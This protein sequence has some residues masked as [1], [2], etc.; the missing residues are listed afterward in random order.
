MIVEDDY[1]GEFRYDRQP[2]GAMQALAPHRVVCC[3]T[4]SK[5]LAPALRLGWLVVP[6]R[7]V[8]SVVEAK[9]TS[10]GQTHLLDQ[11]TLARFIE[12]GGYDRHVRRAR[13]VY[14]RR[15][16]A[17][18]DALASA[19]PSIRVSGVAAG[20]HLVASLPAG[21][22][23]RAAIERAAA[24][25]LVVHGLGAFTFHDDDGHDGH[26]GRTGRDPSLVVGYAAPAEHAFTGA[27]ARLTAALAT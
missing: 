3:G 4:A 19:D 18:V 9:R 16:N 7:L 25:G 27:L 26:D 12:S 11:L 2:V 5:T 15:R 8:D 1:D 14:R 10:D 22:T 23:E 21:L 24:R 13:L 6:E 17:V 20:L